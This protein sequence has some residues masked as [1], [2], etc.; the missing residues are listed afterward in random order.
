MPLISSIFGDFSKLPEQFYAQKV[1]KMTFLVA[2]TQ[3]YKRLCPLVHWSVGPLVR[4]SNGPSVHLHKSKSGKTCI[5]TPAHPSPTGGSVSGLVLL[6]KWNE[7]KNFRCFFFLVAHMF[8]KTNGTVRKN[9]IF[10]SF[11]VCCLSLFPLSPILNCLSFPLNTCLI[12]LSFF[13]PLMMMPKLV[14]KN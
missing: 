11:W 12:S 13:L 14:F 1:L 3:L 9:G 7:Y 8:L 6:K 10:D 4:Q 5:S 2:D